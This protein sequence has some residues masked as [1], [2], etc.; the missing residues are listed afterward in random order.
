MGFSA[1]GMIE[2]FKALG[3][4]LTGIEVGVCRGENLKAILDNCPNIRKIFGVDPY[5]AYSDKLT[6]TQEKVDEWYEKAKEILQSYMLDDSAEL[7]IRPSLEAVQMFGHESIDF[8]YIDGNHLYSMALAD[9]R[10]WWPRI[11]KGGLLSGHDFR[12][13]DVDVRR[14]VADFSKEVGRP[15]VAV[16]SYSWYI[17][18]G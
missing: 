5:T 16:K 10:A 6:I 4:N 17:V 1:E 18:K 11:K 3:D 14:A 7:I 13:K 9:M 12:E 8:V 15:Y 2:H